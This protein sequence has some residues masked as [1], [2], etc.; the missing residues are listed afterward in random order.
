MFEVGPQPDPA[1]AAI[2]NSYAP[3]AETSTASLN[4]AHLI[5]NQNPFD[6]WY[7]MGSL[8]FPPC[9][10]GNLH[11]IVSKRVFSMSKE[12]RD[13]F[14]N[15]FNSGKLKGNWRNLQPLKGNPVNF[16]HFGK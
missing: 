15:M 12:Q 8:T 9:F 1:L 14:Y 2:Q 13:F 16:Y 4:F 3:G 5:N 11:W 10:S 6:F 7:Y